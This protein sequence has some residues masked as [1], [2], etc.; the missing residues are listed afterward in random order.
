MWS[1]LVA[2][3]QHVFSVVNKA[4]QPLAEQPPAGNSLAY[5]GYHEIAW[6]INRFAHVARKYNLIDVCV[7]ALTKIYTLPNIEIHDAFL[8]LREQ[9]KCYLQESTDL[10]AGLDVINNTNLGYFQQAQRSEFFTLKGVFLQHLQMQEEAQHAFSGAI[11][12]DVNLAVGWAKWGQFNDQLFHRKLQESAAGGGSGDRDLT[13]AAHAV[14]CYLN[15]AGLFKN[16]RSRKY[17]ARILWLLGQD[18]ESQTISRA[19]EAYK[20]DMPVWH[21]IS[22]VPQLL[23]ALGKPEARLAKK[24]LIRIAKS[25]PQVC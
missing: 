13:L 1:E 25:F 9:A 17:L 16:H 14:N 18:D 6:I 2:W 3:R 10:S 5:R 24:I 7:N 23:V 11:Q 20:G 4:Y 12:I 8:K 15:A 21:W 22:F 19:F